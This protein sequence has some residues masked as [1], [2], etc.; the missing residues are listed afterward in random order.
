[1]CPWLPGN[2]PMAPSLRTTGLH[3]G[4]Q[5]GTVRF[6]TIYFTITARNIF[7]GIRYGSKVRYFFVLLSN[8]FRANLIIERRPLRYVRNQ[9]LCRFRRVSMTY[10]KLYRVLY[11]VQKKRGPNPLP[12]CRGPGGGSKFFLEGAKSFLVEGA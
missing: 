9:D 4:W 7:L 11:I 3:Q 1:M 12:A 6:G 8:L 2:S 5:Y 10:L